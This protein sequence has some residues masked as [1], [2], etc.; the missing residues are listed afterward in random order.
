MILCSNFKE[1]NEILKKKINR[2]IPT[3]YFK[4]TLLSLITDDRL[5]G[6]TFMIPKKIFTKVGYFDQTLKHTQDYDL[7]IRIAKYY[8]FKHQKN[9]FLV[10][11][12]HSYQSSKV[13]KKDAIEEKIKLFKKYYP[14][15]RNDIIKLNLKEF[16]VLIYRMLKKK[17][18][19]PCGNIVVDYFRQ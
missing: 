14:L 1:Y 4:N 5:H 12:I 6:C 18:Y 16:F 11:R 15:I 13:S 7:W 3:K 17:L 2:K 10:S 19:K 8:E 9:F